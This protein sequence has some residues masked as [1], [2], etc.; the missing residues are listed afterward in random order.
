VCVCV[1]TYIY[2]YN[3]R[4]REKKV[5]PKSTARTKAKVI[6][7]E[8]KHTDLLTASTPRMVANLH[9]QSIPTQKQHV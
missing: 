2:I 5:L 9:A 8:T 6:A 4:E 3:E 1:Y 7:T